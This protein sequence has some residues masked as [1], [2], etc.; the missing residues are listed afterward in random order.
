MVHR[1]DTEPGYDYCFVE[2]RPARQ[3]GEWVPLVFLDGYRSSHESDWDIPAEVLDEAPVY[4][5][6]LV[7]VQLRLRLVSDAIWSSEDGLTCEDGWWIDR[8]EIDHDTVSAADETPSL[9]RGIELSPA[10]PNPFN[11]TTTLAYH[12]PSGAQ[13]VRLDVFDERG[14]RMRTLVDQHPGVGPQSV[15]WDGRDGAGRPV[16]SGSYVARLVVDGKVLTRK[17]ALLK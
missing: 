17:L 1:Y 13:A 11:P 16:A 7:L 12:V 8:V 5:G 6:S 4:E 9:V 14:R 2:V 10:T 3:D 15:R